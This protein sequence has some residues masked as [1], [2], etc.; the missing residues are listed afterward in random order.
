MKQNKEWKI[1]IQRKKHSMKI[2]KMITKM[3][4][5][6][7]KS[8][9]KVAYYYEDLESGITISFNESITFYAASTIKLL[10]VLYLYETHQDLDKTI[11]IQT[12]DKKQ[13]SGIIKNEVLPKTYSLKQLAMTAIKYS[14]NT[15]YIKLVNWIGF[16]QL[17][18]FSKK[19]GMQHGLEGKDSFGI[20]SCR[21]LKIVI[22]KIY[23]YS[24]KDK[25]LK[26]A[27]ENPSYFIIKEKNLNNKKFLR[28]YGSFDIAYHECGIVEDNHPF[29]LILLTQKGKN[30]KSS[31]FINKA[32]KNITKIHHKIQ[33]EKGIQCQKSPK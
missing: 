4:I 17:K 20:T 28:K 22:S 11:K 2:H 13:G 6:F 14:D 9:E 23:E 18:E 19:I 3:N 16:E 8:K 10:A 15:A 30:K 32:A 7:V 1:E 25:E 5:Q 33:R 26:D 27:L 12:E 31:Q 29:Y 21:D 24:K